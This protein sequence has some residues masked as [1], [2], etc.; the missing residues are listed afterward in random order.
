MFLFTINE[1]K[2][3]LPMCLDFVAGIIQVHAV[4]A[5]TRAADGS[6]AGWVHWIRPHS[7]EAHLPGS[8]DGRHSR[9]EEEV[10]ERAEARWRG[11]RVRDNAP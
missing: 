11:L 9:Q 4:E 2:L 5:R 6:R 3:G 10:P 1:S 8:T 7:Q